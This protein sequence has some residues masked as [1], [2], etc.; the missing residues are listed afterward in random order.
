LSILPLGNGDDSLSPFLFARDFFLCPIS[1]ARRFGFFFFPPPPPPSPLGLGDS[2][3]YRFSDQVFFPEWQPPALSYPLS[4]LVVGLSSKLL[5]FFFI[6][7]FFLWRRT[8]VFFPFPLPHLS[9]IVSSPRF[10]CVACFFL[11]IVLIVSPPPLSAAGFHLAMSLSFF[12]TFF[13]S[14]VGS[15]KGFFLFSRS[16]R[17]RLPPF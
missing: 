9:A 6:S 8:M 12:F 15:A 14:W 13:R 16:S 11:T 10:F 3:F 5:Y 7:L 2:F 17:L 1:T 4:P